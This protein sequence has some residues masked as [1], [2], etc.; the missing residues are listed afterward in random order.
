MVKG[1]N[2]DQ[3]EKMAMNAL[4]KVKTGRIRHNL[5]DEKELQ[6]IMGRL[7]GEDRLKKNCPELY[8]ILQYSSEQEKRAANG[9]TSV[10]LQSPSPQEGDTYGLVDS[11]G[12]RTLNY[13]IQTTAYTSSGM[14]MVDENKNLVIVGEL[15]DKTNNQ[16]LDGFAV[17]ASN[18]QELEGDASCQSSSLVR[19]N[20]YEFQAVSTFSKI[21]TDDDGNAR[22]VSDTQKTDAVKVLGASSIVQKLTVNDPMPNEKHSDARQT[23]VYYNNRTGDGCDY[24]YDNV[25]TE[26]KKVEVNLDF[27]G[28]VTFM[29]GFAPLCA[30][31]NKDFMLQL[32][33]NGAANFDTNYWKDIT[34]SVSG[35]TLSWKFPSNWHDW[36]D[37]SKF[38]MTNSAQFYC[39]MYIMTE[40]GLS[41]PI[42]I[43]SMDIEHKDPSYC[44]IRPITIEWGCFAKGT[45]ILMADHTEKCIE[46]IRPG[47]RVKTRGGS[48]AV[49]EVIRG[50]EDTLAVI[51]TGRGRCLLVTPDHPMLTQTGWKRADE[52]NGAD[53]LEMYDGKDIISELHPAGYH[54][55]VFSIRTDSEEALVAEGFYTGDFGCQNRISQQEKKPSPKKEGYQQEVEALAEAL[56]REMKQGK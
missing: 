52:L 28:S 49:K 46:E 4:S 35:K 19:S 33:D 9:L 22:F 10:P 17:A 30:D 26:D 32:I 42:V 5:A 29:D 37:S 3:K 44:A 27:S 47:D 13:D 54:G 24:Y 18:A 2:P 45:R 55:E 34:W 11:V 39:K 51:G 31:K 25:D 15:F 7:G 36:L 14:S 20:D 48:A 12:I 23:V 43:S 16:S 8:K 50:R 38:H 56:N 21:V 53:V 40:I 6:F 1:M 41:I